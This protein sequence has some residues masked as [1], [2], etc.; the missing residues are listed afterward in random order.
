MGAR[1]VGYVGK[2]VEGGVGLGREALAV[3]GED[4]PTARRVR[5]TTAGASPAVDHGNPTIAA[6]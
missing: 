3:G 6:G 5:K 4:R 2:G 1:R